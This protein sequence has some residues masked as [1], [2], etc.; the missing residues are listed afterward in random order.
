V[1]VRAADDSRALTIIAWLITLALAGW[2]A[3]RLLAGDLVGF[4]VL[5]GAA[6]AIAVFIAATD[7][8]PI[9]DLIAAF[10]GLVNAGAYVAGL[11]EL[12]YYDEAVHTYT[13]FAVSS[14]FGY[15]LA[16]RPGWNPREKP[17]GFSSTVV[18]FGL[19]AGV[20]W[21]ILE[22]FVINLQWWDTVTDLM[23]DTIGSLLAAIFVAW[24]VKRQE[25]G[26]GQI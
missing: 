11:W 13:G 12:P 21:E 23:A 17:W 15:L 20:V 18:A 7:L 26:R 8:P 6:A 5:A 19:A 22:W 1:A 2:G 3:A 9:F 4:A 24:K 25:N 10:T 16:R 14:V